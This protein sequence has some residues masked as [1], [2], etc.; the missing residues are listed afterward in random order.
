M[1]R[2]ASGRQSFLYCGIDQV[3]L[4]LDNGRPAN[5]AD[6]SALVA[7][8]LA[9]L[10]TQIRDGKRYILEAV[11]GMWIHTTVPIIRGPKNPAATP[12]CSP[13]R[14]RLGRFD[15]EVEPEGTYADDKRSDIKL[16]YGGFNVPVEIKTQ[17]P[18]RLVDRHPEPARE[19]V[20]TRSWSRGIWNLSRLLVRPGRWLQTKGIGRL[21][22]TRRPG[23]GVQAHGNSFSDLEQ[24][25][26]SVCVI[27]VSKPELSP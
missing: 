13:C 24:Y 3:I 12:S 18:S 22:P 17:L 14:N 8:E 20:H 5:A 19:E 7:M 6:L 16:C 26:I 25:R 23:T 11:S 2:H 10:S 27:D 9:Q 4:T 21:G 15:V 1:R